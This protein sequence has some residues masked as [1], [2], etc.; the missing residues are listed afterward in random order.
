M[1]IPYLSAAI[2]AAAFTHMGAMSVKIAFLTSAL[3]AMILFA[4]SFGAYMLW[5]RRYG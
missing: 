5:K 3:N 2:L 4:I 1:L